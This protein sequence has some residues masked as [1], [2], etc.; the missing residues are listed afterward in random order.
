MSDR[1]SDRDSLNRHGTDSLSI[2]DLL[3]QL[4]VP[5]V[6]VAVIDDFEVL[7]TRAWGVA[8]RESR[9]RATEE[10]LYQAASISKPVAAMASLKA[11]QLGLF[12]LD[13][14]VNTILTSWKLPDAPFGGGPAV[15]PR[16]LMSHTAGLGDGFGFSG[17]EPGAP[18]PTVRQILDG[19]LPSP[20]PAV[21]LVRPAM[22]GYHYSG[23]GIQIEQLVLT[24]VVGRPFAHIMDDW[25]LQPIGMA[26]SSFEQPL[27]TEREHLAARAHDSAGATMNAR[28]H[29]YPEQAAAGLWTTP[30]DLARFMVE[31]QRTLAGRSSL[32][33][34]R[35]TM[36]N[37][38]TPVGVGP[39]AVGFQVS[40]K[41]E[42]WYVEHP[43]DNWGFKATVIAHISNGYGAVI[44][45]N[46][47]NGR[48]IIA[49]IQDRIA[50]SYGWDLL[51]K[52]IPR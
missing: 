44:M 2:D 28:W 6:S 7:W 32:I 1:A 25:I 8:D 5:S 48:S 50:E 52:P 4:Q 15:T 37:M 9:A 39:F 22:A 41:G 34:D 36:Q 13:Q 49:E 45:T 46:G 10:T 17:Y 11:A 19:Q 30:G 40:Q 3:E 14:D 16:M 24:D 12:D 47:D 29:V 43:G 27:P 20:S 35:G 26:S 23:G 33:L 18:L 51:D 38:V 42:G 31:F 21:R